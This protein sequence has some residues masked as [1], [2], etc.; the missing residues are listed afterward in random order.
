MNEPG[1]QRCPFCGA[2]ESDRFTLEGQRFLVFPCHFSP[3]IDPRLSEEELSHWLPATFQ[4]GGGAYFRGMCDKLHLYVV[5]GR[6][7]HE[8]ASGGVAEKAA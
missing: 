2:L 3:E 5:K 4:V 6:G 7:A 8:L 1:L